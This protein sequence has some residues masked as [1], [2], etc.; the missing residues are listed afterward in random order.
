[1]PLLIA[2]SGAAVDESGA[3]V[4]A[5]ALGNPVA[6]GANGKPV[7]GDGNPIPGASVKNGVVIGQDGQP[8]VTDA[9][10]NPIQGARANPRG[11]ITLPGGATVA[12]TSSGEPLGQKNGQILDGNGNP[13]PNVKVGQD[14]T[15]TDQKGN[16]LLLDVAGNP[17]FVSPDGVPLDGLGTKIPGA[18]VLNNTAVDHLQDPLVLDKDGKPLT[19]QREVSCYI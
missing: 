19:V 3:P 1:M 15:V 5:D 12:K 11:G 4:A 16:S 18:S 17:I 9:S 6:L 2:P 8:I 14:G 10:G 13:I 7:D